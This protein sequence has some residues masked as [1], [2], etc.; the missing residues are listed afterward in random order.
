M[1]QAL[2][3]RVPLSSKSSSSQ[4]K[5]HQASPMPTAMTFVLS[6]RTLTWASLTPMML[7]A[8]EGLQLFVCRFC[9][10]HIYSQ[11]VNMVLCVY[12]CVLMYTH[13]APTKIN[14]C[15]LC[16]CRYIYLYTS[17]PKHNY[18]PYVY[19]YVNTQIYIISIYHRR[20]KYYMYIFCYKVYVLLFL[21]P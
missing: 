2:C 18:N 9:N 3:C 11:S 6:Q 17:A 13:M 8:S 12:L 20:M 10:V 21:K 16:V 14:K 7:T 5:M 19:I 15:I 4:R 1:Q